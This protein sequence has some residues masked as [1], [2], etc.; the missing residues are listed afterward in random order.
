MSVELKDLLCRV[1]QEDCERRLSEVVSGLGRFES[2]LLELWRRGSMDVA[3]LVEGSKVSSSD[4]VA[5]DMLMLERAG[6]VAGETKYT[7]RNE[8]RKYVLTGKGRIL[9]ERLAEGSSFS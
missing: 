1:V 8:Y 4:T 2:L 7:H 6:L 9:A 3:L 5:K